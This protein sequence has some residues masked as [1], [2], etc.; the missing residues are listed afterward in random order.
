MVV[1]VIQEGIAQ[2]L[3]I[4]GLDEANLKIFICALLSFPFS[5]IFKR[6][7]DN[8]YT[9]KNVYVI[10]VATVYVFGILD[11]TDGLVSL[12]FSALG[13]YFITRY[14]KSS[15]MP[16]INFLF[17]MG[18][19]LSKH[20]E[21][22]FF[23][24]YDPTKI[25]ITGAQMV[26]VMKLS[27]FG[28]SI[29]D[30]KK[31]PESLTEYNKSRQIKS[32]PNILPY[33]GY[34]FFYASLLTGPAFDYADYDKFIHGTL[35][36]DVP[37]SKRP[38]KT[39]K[40]KIPKS[41]KQAAYK[42]FQGFAW[43]FI[44]VNISKWISVDYMLSPSMVNDHGFIYRIFYFW[45][46][47]F[48]YRLKYYAIWSIAEGACILSGIGYNGYDETTGDFKWNRVQNIDPWAFETGQNIH[49]CL[50]AWNMNTNKWLKNYIYLRV[51]KP[52]K[53]P[54]FRSTLFTFAT[55]AAWHGTRPGYYLTFVSGAFLQSCGKIF[56]R[57]F[58]PIFL[59]SDGK[60]GKSYKPIYDIVCYFVTQLALAQA[61]QPFVLLDLGTS[62]YAWSICYFFAHIGIF[63]TLFLFKGPYAKQVTKFCKSYQDCTK[64]QKQAT[65]KVSNSGSVKL[66]DEESRIV[67][68][69]ISKKVDNIRDTTFDYATLGLPSIDILESV[70]KDDVDDE[71]K[72]FTSA[73]DS[74][75]ARAFV[76]DV[77]QTFSNF[78]HEVQDIY[79]SMKPQ[80]DSDKKNS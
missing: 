14:V 5:W 46:L 2:L 43:A 52:G 75:K 67:E 57:N 37:E 17:L 62:I 51:A 42:T 54:G 12:L 61:V 28:W 32:H 74:F 50:E 47:G 73:W 25:D 41:G 64:V 23:N 63:I 59:E 36:D 66:N 76:E 9:L 40:R 71:I 60:T 53:G 19:L 45:A 68:S 4:I 44:F 31:S 21:M 16:W 24:D 39:R 70:D 38:G 3:D 35:F 65:A 22:Q 26:L 72:Q 6:L 58:R 8:R 78:T 13:C 49:I 20:I 56:R 7:P 10:G 55:S 69:A 33:L 34:V 27:A 1:K 29:H 77:E 30:G 11:L 48:S 15:K 18:H 80:T 79:H